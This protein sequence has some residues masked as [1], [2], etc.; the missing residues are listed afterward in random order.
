MPRLALDLGVGLRRV[1]IGRG[2]RSGGTPFTVQAFPRLPGV[3]G[4]FMTPVEASLVCNPRDGVVRPTCGWRAILKVSHTDPSLGSDFDFTRYVADVGYLIPFRRGAR[5]LALRVNGG[6]IDGKPR[7]VPF[8][9]LEE[10]GGDDTEPASAGAMPCRSRSPLLRFHVRPARLLTSSTWMR[11]IP[12][13][14]AN[15]DVIGR[16]AMD[17]SRLRDGSGGSREQNGCGLGTAGSIDLGVSTG[18]GGHAFYREKWKRTG[19]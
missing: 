4:G 9:E 7:A 19:P 6:F 18:A 1:D 8:W 10:L 11:R 14:R 16:V 12:Q 17:T 13:A 5:V 15:R 2:D 3:K